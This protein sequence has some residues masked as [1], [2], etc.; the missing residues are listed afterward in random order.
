MQ[1]VND[2]LGKVDNN[3]ASRDAKVLPVD[4][5]ELRPTTAP[6]VHLLRTLVRGPAVEGAPRPGDTNALY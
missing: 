2:C 3:G 6:R 5:M 4:R 1:P